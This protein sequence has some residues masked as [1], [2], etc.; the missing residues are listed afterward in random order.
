MLIFLVKKLRSR[1]N[2]EIA[3][4]HALKSAYTFSWKKKK[5]MEVWYR[6]IN[7]T[8]STIWSK[9]YMRSAFLFFR[10]SLS[11]SWSPFRYLLPAA[12]M[13]SETFNVKSDSSFF[14]CIAEQCT[15]VCGSF[16]TAARFFAKPRT[17]QA[18]IRW[19]VIFSAC[20]CR[21]C[22]MSRGKHS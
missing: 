6:V 16:N 4:R 12:M 3:K 17:R 14:Q 2:S 15:D 10:F 5:K 13:L 20:K 22:K 9:L 1:L 21:I 7:I 19:T 18:L 8:N 11:F